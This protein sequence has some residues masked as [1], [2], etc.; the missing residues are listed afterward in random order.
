MTTLWAEVELGDV[1]TLQRGFDL[2]AQHRKPGSIPIVSSSGISGYHNEA[3]VSGPGVVTGR[4]GTLGEIYYITEDYWPHNTTLYVKDFKGNEPRF[5]YYLL[6][7]LGFATHNSASG[8]PGVNRNTLH[9]LPV[10]QPPLPVQRHIADI[11]GALD[12]K[13]Q[14]NRRISATLES[15]ARALFKHWFVDFGPFQGGPFVETELGAVPKGW[16]RGSI[17]DQAKLLSGGTPSTSKPQYWG[18]SIAWASAKDVSQC[19]DMFLMSTERNITLEGLNNSPTQM[20]EKF[21]TVVVA[22]GAT[23]GRLVMLA[24]D[25]AMN[26]TCY[27]LRSKINYNFTLYCQIEHVIGELV[28]SAHGSVFDTITTAT[29]RSHSVLL[30][31]PE[32]LRQ[33]E[34][35]VTPLFEL[36]LNHTQEIQRLAATRDYLLPRLLSGEVAVEAAEEETAGVL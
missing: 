3:R 16:Y 26:Q 30:P 24:S 9:R 36:I 31:P 29:F 18:G 4:Y 13:I 32:V 14:V 2:P 10:R 6:R 1:I 22:R 33:F 8:V 34:A 17:L 35:K 20:I 21:S 28:Q 7:T 27:A 23:T 5:V 12:D 25:M 15:M 19:H 11:L